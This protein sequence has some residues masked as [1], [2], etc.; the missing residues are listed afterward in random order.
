MYTFVY[1]VVLPDQM[2][3][4]DRQAFFNAVNAAISPVVN[5]AADQYNFPFHP[6]TYVVDQDNTPVC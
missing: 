2:S 3:D 1:S 6:S 5:A 4:Q